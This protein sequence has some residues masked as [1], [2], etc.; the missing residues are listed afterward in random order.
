MGLCACSPHLPSS[1]EEAADSQGYMNYS[2]DN[3][4]FI[5]RKPEVHHRGH[6]SPP[7]DYI[8]SQ[9]NP[10]DILTTH[11]RPAVMLHFHMRLRLANG[12]TVRY[13]LTN[14]AHIP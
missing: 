6:N 1:A 14:T 11:Q 13:F 12:F 7:L 2:V 9:L 4:T 3:N 5:A 8:L 10:V